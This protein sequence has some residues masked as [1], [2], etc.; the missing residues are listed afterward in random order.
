MT[1][2]ESSRFVKLLQAILARSKSNKINNLI[3]TYQNNSDFKTLEEL[4][5][6]HYSNKLTCQKGGSI[7]LNF[8][9]NKDNPIFSAD[10]CTN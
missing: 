6:S 1:P 3:C 7:S 10:Y 8:F 2:E 4:Y 5:N 9:V